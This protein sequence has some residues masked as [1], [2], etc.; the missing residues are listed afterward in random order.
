MPR[1][2]KLPETMLARF[3]AGTFERIDAALADG[4]V[5]A[6]FVRRAVEAEIDRRTPE[7]PLAAPARSVDVLP[8]SAV[9]SGS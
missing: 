5:R 7:D 6:E 4:E 9:G 8:L 2:L 1:T 3:P